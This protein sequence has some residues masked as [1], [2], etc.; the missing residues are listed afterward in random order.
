M[1]ARQT[2]PAGAAVVVVA[3]AGGGSSD[4]EARDIVVTLFDIYGSLGVAND[5][6]RN[7]GQE[8]NTTG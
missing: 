4:R 6:K 3:V 8:K 5:K 1:N 7:K 2:A